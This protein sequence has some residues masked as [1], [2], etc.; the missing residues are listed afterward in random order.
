MTLL[1]LDSPSNFPAY[2]LVQFNVEDT[3]AVVP[4]SRI[5]CT[6]SPQSM[7][8]GDSVMVLWHNMKRYKGTF[9]LSGEFTLHYHVLFIVLNIIT[10]FLC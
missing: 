9:V 6:E 4:I 1:S 5:T 2:A 8:E 3:T 7:K 10:C